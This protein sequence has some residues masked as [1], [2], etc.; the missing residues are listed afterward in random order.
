M[1]LA[2]NEQE[3]SLG[4]FQYRDADTIELKPESSNPGHQALRVGSDTGDFQIVG[5]VGAVIGPR[6]AEGAHEVAQAV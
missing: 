4:R 5:V 3:M 6:R 1:K 2:R